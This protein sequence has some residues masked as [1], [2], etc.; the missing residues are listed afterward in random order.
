MANELNVDEI[1]DRAKRAQESRLAAIQRVVEA[2]QALIDERAAT[3]KELAELQATIAQRLTASQQNDLRAYTASLAA[4][5]TPEELKKIGFAEPE[6]KARA[7]RRTTRAATTR[8]T[9]ATNDGSSQDPSPAA[10]DNTTTSE[11]PTHG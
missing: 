1:M 3:D 8:S 2:R 10:G 9:R 5:W 7:R 6:K 4:G 11:P